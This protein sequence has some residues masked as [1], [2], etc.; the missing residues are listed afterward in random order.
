VRAALPTFCELAAEQ[1]T[2]AAAHPTHRRTCGGGFSNTLY[3]CT[4]IGNTSDGFGGGL[5]YGILS[6]CLL[7]SNKTTQFSS[8]G[9]GANASTLT[10]CTLMGNNGFN[11]GGVVNSTLVNCAL[12]NNTAR[13]FGGGAMS[14]TL[15]ACT[16]VGNKSGRDGGGAF[17]CT[18]TNCTLSNNV[19]GT[20]FYGGGAN[21]S[22]LDNCLVISNTA[23]Y[24]GG[25][26]YGTVYR[27]KLLNNR[28]VT[29]GG[30]GFSA[31]MNN[32][33]LAGNTSVDGGGAYNG[34]F[35]NCTIVGNLVTFRGGGLYNASAVN[36]IVY[37]NTGGNANYLNYYFGVFTNSCT[38][39]LPAS[40]LGNIDADPQFVNAGIN[41]YHL[42]A[43]SPCRNA[44]DNAYV[45]T[46]I[47]LDG[48]PRLIS[49]IVD[50]GVYESQA[51]NVPVAF[52]LSGSSQLS[53]GAFQLS[54]TNLSGLGF[55]VLGST[56]V[57]L[58]VAQWTVLGAPVENPPGRYQFTDPQATNKATRFY[59]VRS[60]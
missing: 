5:N 27:C 51:T 37:L 58:P 44:G 49:A 18:L 26:A 55:T 2:T 19:A 8:D 12:S 39:P 28:G 40:G 23:T 60:P 24:G 54:F 35:T 22:T 11:G 15:S 47:D 46:A 33:L 20:T 32:C 16:L 42:Q 56:N 17:S 25:V 52:R 50:M 3:R 29:Q 6:S 31:P 9:G 14:S 4:L 10:D 57:A 30:G 59:R 45:S 38:L 1:L 41:D 36:C 43:S 48:N 7:I 13:S 53:G 34:Y 21:N